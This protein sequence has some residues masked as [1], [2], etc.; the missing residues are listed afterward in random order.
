LTQFPVAFS[1][2]N[3]EKRAPVPALMESTT[4]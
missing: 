3:S 1:G 4:P 2:G